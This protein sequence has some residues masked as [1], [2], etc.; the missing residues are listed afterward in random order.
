MVETVFFFFI[1]VSF[2]QNFWSWTFVST[3]TE[4]WYSV[5]VSKSTGQYVYATARGGAGHIYIEIKIMV[6]QDIGL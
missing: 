2:F 6:L 4:N 5:A 3:T 1:I